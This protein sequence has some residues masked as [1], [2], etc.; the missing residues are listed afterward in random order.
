VR[1]R[2]RELADGVLAYRHPTLDLT[3]GLVLGTR[4]CL[5]IDTGG[6]VAWGARL[7]GQVRRITTLPWTVALT[8]GHFD[9]CFGTAGFVGAP[10]WA[11]P[12]CRTAIERTATAQRERWVE[13]FRT[14]DGVE[15]D[16][17]RADA[18]AATEPA[19]PGELTDPAP[20]APPVRL[21]LGGLHAELHHL[22]P[23]H[24]DH[25]L[26]VHVPQRGVLFA[27]D[28]LESGGPPDFEDA[29][30]AHWASTVDAM[31]ALRPR[32]LVPG[33]G[34]PM[35]PRQAARQ[36]AELAVVA[37]LCARQARGDH[38]DDL[39]AQSPYPPATTRTALGRPPG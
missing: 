7:A 22:G 5:V 21:D 23:G 20:G 11:H 26:V 6:D 2:W 28:L 12:G 15:P 36:R 25:D 34:D 31:L 8:H 9:H 3:T 14:G 24:T 27:G 30:P 32:V 37:A 38:P 4:G 1:G 16:P 10:V 17:V 13:A 19:L 18:L 33:H 39:V 35:E 29:R